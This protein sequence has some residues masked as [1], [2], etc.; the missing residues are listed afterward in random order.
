[1]WQQ[2]VKSFVVSCC[3]LL[4]RSLKRLAHDEIQSNRTFNDA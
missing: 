2:R 4:E 1:M 3:L